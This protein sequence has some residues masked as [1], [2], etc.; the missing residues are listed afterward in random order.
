M[1]GGL[2]QAA[3]EAIGL[4]IWTATN[5][6]PITTSIA[7]IAFIG[8]GAGR[9]WHVVL[10]GMLYAAGGA[11]TY[12]LLAMLLTAGVQAAPLADFLQHYVNQM[13]G[14]LLIV[15]GMILLEIIRMP[16][17]GFGVGPG[18][19]ARVERYGVWAALPLGAL[20]ALA[21]C[22]V[23][24]ACFF[25]SVFRLSLQ[26]DSRVVVPLLY[27]AGTA[28]PVLAFALLLGF[29]SQVMGKAFNAVGRV[30]WW[31]QRAAGAVLVL[32]GIYLSVKYV[33]SP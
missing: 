4:G 30:Q 5:P 18:L 17:M 23:S 28:V 16:A 31:V 12:V 22:P 14:P 6:C 10:G 2:G 33:F 3:I 20:L 25:V 7:A 32:V 8:R 15:V 1:A 19:Q 29:G 24:A 9:P 11:A 27:G 13:L 26:Y 21:F